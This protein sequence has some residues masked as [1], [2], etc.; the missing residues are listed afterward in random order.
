MGYSAGENDIFRLFS[1]GDHGFCQ[2]STAGIGLFASSGSGDH[3]GNLRSAGVVGE[4]GFP[5]VRVDGVA[6]DVLSGVVDTGG[7]Y[8]SGD[9]V[10]DLPQSGQG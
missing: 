7:G 9:A 6:V 4:T 3:S 10:F 2:R 8:K 1:V 5:P